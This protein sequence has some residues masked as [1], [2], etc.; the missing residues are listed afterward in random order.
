MLTLAAILL[1]RRGALRPVRLRGV[2][3]GAGAL[4]VLA[5][6]PL[7]AATGRA[8]VDGGVAALVPLLRLGAIAFE[9]LFAGIAAA[10]PRRIELLVLVVVPLRHRLPPLQ[11]PP[12][13][14]SPPG[15]GTRH[16]RCVPVAAKLVKGARGVM[17]SH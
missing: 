7:R 6:R 10:L 13:A 17:M 12:P 9:G 8:A 16:A 5:A 11:V 15:R 1:W 2:A 3:L 4:A 14:R